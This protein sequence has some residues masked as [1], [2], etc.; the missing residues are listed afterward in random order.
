ML[1]VYGTPRSPPVNC[2]RFTANYLALDY[3]FVFVNQMEGE[4]RSEW[5]MKLHPAGKVPSID[6]DGFTMFESVAICRYLARKA[7]S[8]I[9]PADISAAAIVDA[10]SHFAENHVYVA[11]CKVLFNHFYTSMMG[12]EVDER[13]LREGREW[14]AR[15]LPIVDARIDE[16]GNVAGATFSLADIILLASLDPVEVSEVD[17]APYPKLAA[18]RENLRSQPFYTACHGSYAEAV[19]QVQAEPGTNRHSYWAREVWMP[20]M[21]GDLANERSKNTNSANEC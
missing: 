3:E 4:H 15:F 18:W 7:S 1:K 21:T 5:Y 6:D 16:H 20:H 13:S 19:E 8:P 17:L 12:A 9:Y 14:L 2:V 11:I 10:W